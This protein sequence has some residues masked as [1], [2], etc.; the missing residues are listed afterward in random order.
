MNYEP[1]KYEEV[2]SVDGI[3]GVV[4]FIEFGKESHKP[5]LYT[6]KLNKGEIVVGASWFKRPFIVIDEQSQN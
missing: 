5:V 4:E 6:V 1:R 3:E 2:E